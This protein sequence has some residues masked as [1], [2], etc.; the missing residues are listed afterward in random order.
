MILQSWSTMDKFIS[1]RVAISKETSKGPL[2]QAPLAQAPL[3]PN[4]CNKYYKKVAGN[5]ETT[6]FPEQIPV[7]QFL[8]TLCAEN[9]KICILL[10]VEV[11]M[12]ILA[13]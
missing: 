12:Q 2:C 10:V 3:T 13:A 6:L 8:S 7:L 1:Y 4:G 11:C 9:G 5:M